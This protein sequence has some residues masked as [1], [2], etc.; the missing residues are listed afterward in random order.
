MKWR[1]GTMYSSKSLMKLGTLFN[2]AQSKIPFCSDTQEDIYTY[3][4]W[5]MQNL[6]NHLI[7]STYWWITCTL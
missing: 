3:L 1:H 6:G 7:L 5:S 4:S 2:T